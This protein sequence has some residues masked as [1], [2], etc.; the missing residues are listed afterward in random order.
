[1][2]K[3]RPLIICDVDEVVLHFVAPFEQFLHGRGL[4]LVKRSY[5][6]T[7]N[8]LDRSSGEVFPSE[9]IGR[10]TESFFEEHAESQPLIDGAGD[11][12]S[13]LAEEADICFLT[14]V[15]AHCSEMR[16][17]NLA[18]HGLTFPVYAN[19]GSKGGQAAEIAGN[20]GRNVLFI[21]DIGPNLV[22]V[23][24]AIPDVHL[25]HF[26]NDPE[27]FRLAPEVD[28]V[29]HRAADWQ[30]AHRIIVTLLDIGM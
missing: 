16:Q 9:N 13:L 26:V 14:N 5:A 8:I 1:M 7:G 2:T 30:E 25:I 11:A 23:R 18:G 20:T 17:R 28:G 6:L 4:K 19:S 21:D 12:L 10:L 15:P 3:D 27:F 22:S 29:E 24:K